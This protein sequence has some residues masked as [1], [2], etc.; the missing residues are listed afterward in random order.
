M[1]VDKSMVTTVPANVQRQPPAPAGARAVRRLTPHAEDREFLPAAVEILETPPSVIAVSFIW[2]ICTVFAA[3]IAWSYFGKLDIYAVAA[4]KVQLAGRSKVVQ[5]LDPGK[6]A[7][8]LVEN[9]SRVK[10][11]DVLIELDPTE[12]TADRDKLSR[13]LSSA[14]AEAARRRAAIEQARLGALAAPALVT[15]DT[16]T[17]DAVRAR[18][19]KV[20]AADLAQLGASLASLAADLAKSETTERKLRD[21]IAQREKLIALSRERVQMREELSTRGAG[22]RALVIEALTQLETEMTTQVSERGQLRETAAA[23]HFTRQKMAEAV[24]QFVADQSQKLAE[25]E[26]KRDQ[27]MQDLVKAQTRNERTRLKAPVSGIVQQLAVT[28]VGQVVNSGQALMTI[29][30]LEAPIEIEAMILNKDIGFVAA[31]QPAVVKVDAFPFSRYGTLTGTVVKVS[32]DAVDMRDSPNL[33]DAAAAVK[34]QGMSPNTPSSRPELAFPATIKLE[35]R[36]IDIDGHEVNLSPG[37]TAT[38]EIKTGR[39]RVIDYVLSPLREVVS[40]TAHER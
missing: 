29:V 38:V 36:S 25:A 24:S 6:V 37:M 4:G 18:E 21:S 26:R 8:V 11:G 30:P 19:E 23:M 20:L 1:P 7:A 3:A 22:S 17:S 39:R 16:G 13:D 28:T 2:L 33:S 9:G 10:E 12:T 31:G 27:L 34:A 14:D 5:P 15:F 32:S 40:Q 35:Q